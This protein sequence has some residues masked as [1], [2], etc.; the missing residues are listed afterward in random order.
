MRDTLRGFGNPTPDN[1]GFFGYTSNPRTYFEVIPYAKLLHDA[2]A[3]NAIFFQ[4]L[5]L[6]DHG[7]VASEVT[8]QP[9]TRE[10]GSDVAS[11]L[12]S[13]VASK[14]DSDVASSVQGSATAK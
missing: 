1:E 2:Q 7:K 3:R 6:N 4:K 12:G 14:L 8:L 13:D 9:D 5:G 10:V 11:K